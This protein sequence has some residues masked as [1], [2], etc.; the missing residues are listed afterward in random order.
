MASSA[1]IS[2]AGEAVGGAAGAIW[3]LGK[4]GLAGGVAVE[5]AA[6]TGA[7]GAPPNCGERSNWV[8]AALGMPLL[9]RPLVDDTDPRGA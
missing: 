3:G 5:R 1:A 6:G 4:A 8:M 2:G 7:L 9:P